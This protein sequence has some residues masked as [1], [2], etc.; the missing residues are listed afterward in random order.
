M[1]T[2]PRQNLTREHGE[3]LSR[4]VSLSNDERNGTAAVVTS[5][6]LVD[7][8]SLYSRTRGTLYELYF[9]AESVGAFRHMR[10]FRPFAP[11]GIIG[12]RTAVDRS[13]VWINLIVPLQGRIDRF[14]AFLKMYV[15]VCVKQ[16][17]RVFLTV[18]YFGADGRT[19]AEEILKKMARDNNYEHYK[20]LTT[21]WK[22][23]RGRALQHGAEQL[24]KRNVLMFFCDV[25]IIFDIHFLDRCRMHARPGRQVYYPTVFSLY[26][27]DIV[28]ASK[29]RPS[30]R[31][32]LAIEHETGTWRQYGYGMT[33]L[34][35]DDFFS[36]GGFDL[37][38]EGWGGE[39][40]DLLKKFKCSSLEIFRAVD[41]GLF[42]LYHE[43]LCDPELPDEKYEHCTRNRAMYEGSH[44]QLGLQVLNL[45]INGKN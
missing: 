27:P 28:Y 29:S 39:D 43:K 20:F 17:N 21:D 23:S 41:R 24:E 6:D 44:R 5:R 33:C 19:Q 4:A 8:F 42:H 13:D 25:D 35:R 3:V 38:I 34:Y 16:D 36:V 45:T 31:K 37:T 22:F 1:A 12:N 7:G 2:I 11:V 14:T 30:V 9:H 32:Q 26:N 40:N 15:D 18:V 10:L